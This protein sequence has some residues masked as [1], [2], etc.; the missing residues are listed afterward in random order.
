VVAQTP[1]PLFIVE[2]ARKGSV[3]KSIVATRVHRPGRLGPSRAGTTRG[4]ND[5]PTVF[6]LKFDFGRQLSVIEQHFGNADAFGVADSDDS[7]LGDHVIT[8]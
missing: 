4:A 3:E 5:E 6:G 2:P 7:R 8:L 1:S